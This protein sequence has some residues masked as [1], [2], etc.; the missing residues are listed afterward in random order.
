[1][2]LSGRQ[3]LSRGSDLP[4]AGKVGTQETV[5]GQELG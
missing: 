1:M 2:S 4:D 5:K 3:M